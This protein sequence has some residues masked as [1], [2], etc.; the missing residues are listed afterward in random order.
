M[1]NN[2]NAIKFSAVTFFPIN[3]LVLFLISGLCLNGAISRTMAFKNDSSF[4]DLLVAIGLLAY[5]FILFYSSYS[6]YIAAND[7]KKR[8]FVMYIS[9]VLASLPV[10]FLITNSVGGMSIATADG[11]AESYFSRLP[12]YLFMTFN[13]LFWEHIFIVP[14]ILFVNWFFIKYFSSKF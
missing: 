4:Y 6:C 11:V 2:L 10:I 8:L 9:W 13:G 3:L 7:F 14:W 12:Q 5:Y 1:R